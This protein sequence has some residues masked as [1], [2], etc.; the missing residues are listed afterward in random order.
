MEINIS[1][2]LGSPDGHLFQ[3]SC[4]LWHTRLSFVTFVSMSEYISPGPPLLMVAVSA[5][6][7]LVVLAKMKRDDVA[8]RP[9]AG[10]SLVA[11]N[12][13][14]EDGSFAGKVCM[15]RGSAAWEEEKPFS[16]MPSP[17]QT[18]PKQVLSSSSSSS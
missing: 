6:M 16:P 14:G 13:S 12:A 10:P 15:C 2:G 18:S 7:H 1:V 11:R 3:G 4:S 9:W 17:L 5:L 8:G